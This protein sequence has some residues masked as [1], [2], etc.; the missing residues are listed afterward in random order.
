MNFERQA[1]RAGHGPMANN[2]PPPCAPANGRPGFPFCFV[3]AGGR[4]PKGRRGRFFKCAVLLLLLRCGRGMVPGRCAHSRRELPGFPGSRVPRRC[5]KNTGSRVPARISAATGTG[6]DPP[7]AILTSLVAI[8][9]T[10]AVGDE[11]KNRD[12][13]PRSRAGGGGRGHN[14]Q[15][16]SSSGPR[17][18]RASVIRTF[19]IPHLARGGARAAGR[20]RRGRPPLSS[21]DD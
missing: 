4:L 18:M 3:G 11:K 15:E 17:T 21:D 16:S 1:L 13:R 12:K 20:L 7:A 19:A 6:S 14:G 9:T 2:G 8:A 5:A 10:T